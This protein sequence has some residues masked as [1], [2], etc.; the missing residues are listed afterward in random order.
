MPQSKHLVLDDDV[1]EALVGRRDMTGMPISRIGNDILRTHI[2]AVLLD[3]LIGKKLVEAG[4]LSHAEYRDVLHQASEELHRIFQPGHAPVEVT[5]DGTLV[6]GSWKL[7][8]VYRSDDSAFQL[9]ECWARDALKQPMG[10][11]SHSA[12]EFFI[13]VGGRCL[14]VME[15]FPFTLVK[16]NVLQVPAGA[17][18]SAVPLDTDCHLLVLTI[19]AT[20]EYSP[21]PK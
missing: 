1:Y 16:G 6:S 2:S 4:R 7:A 19:P 18:H 20:P 3:D 13:A 12:D 5:E 15:G 21:H 11:H 17:T 8:S 10:Q 9:I 14:L